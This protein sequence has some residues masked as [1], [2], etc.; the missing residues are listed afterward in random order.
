M[1]GRMRGGTSNNLV[2]SMHFRDGTP[3]FSLKGNHDWWERETYN[4][5][6]VNR[7]RFRD[8]TPCFSLKSE[9]DCWDMTRT[10][11]TVK[12][13]LGGNVKYYWSIMY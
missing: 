5:S 13:T 11:K 4:R 7:M 1:I 3:C 6:P 9:N 8:G 2:N 10:G 12:Y